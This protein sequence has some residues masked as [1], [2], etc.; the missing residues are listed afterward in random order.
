MM[1]SNIALEK[2][3]E[4]VEEVKSAAL[5]DMDSFDLFELQNPEKPVF[6]ALGI[7]LRCRDDE[8]CYWV[9]GYD[10]YEL[11]LR[12]NPDLMKYMRQQS[13]YL[14]EDDEPGKESAKDKLY[15]EVTKYPNPCPKTGQGF[16]LEVYT[17]VFHGP[18]CAG[19]I[20]PVFTTIDAVQGFLGKVAQSLRGVAQGLRQDVEHLLLVLCQAAL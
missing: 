3:I 4:I 11:F 19:R 1:K 2:Y 7:K 9:F 10:S 18:S 5:Y 12:F 17:I 15:W 16:G 6:S 20:P 14:L 13:K 8:D